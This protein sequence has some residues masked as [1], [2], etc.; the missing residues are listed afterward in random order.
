MTNP[1]MMSG[2]M[3]QN[4]IGIIPQVRNTRTI[5]AIAVHQAAVLQELWIN[6][7]AAE[8]WITLDCL[9]I[10]MGTFV[11]YFFSGFILGKIP[12]PLSPS[13]RLMLQ[14]MSGRSIILCFLSIPGLYCLQSHIRPRHCTDAS[15]DSTAIVAP[16]GGCKGAI[17]LRL[18]AC[19]PNI[20]VDMD[21]VQRGVDLPSLDVTYFTSLSYYILLLFGLRGVFMLFFRE[22]TID[23]TQMYRC[24]SGLYDPIRYSSSRTF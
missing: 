18:P 17:A 2:L 23:E 9:Q 6:L 1:D 11:S 15:S 5:A 19:A 16:C 13:F 14:V 3:K 4:L 24:D 12:F 21:V 20:S 8:C 7:I 10:A 22:N